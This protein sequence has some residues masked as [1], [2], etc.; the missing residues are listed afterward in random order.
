MG[1]RARGAETGTEGDASP[2]HARPADLEQTQLERN[3]ASTGRSLRIGRC[4]ESTGFAAIEI[5]ITVS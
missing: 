5:F 1:W 4:I 3:R 2:L